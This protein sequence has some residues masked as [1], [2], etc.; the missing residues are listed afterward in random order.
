MESFFSHYQSAFLSVCAI[1][2]RLPG[3]TKI[4]AITPTP[5]ATKAAQ[6]MA[7]YP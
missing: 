3:F 6:N 1:V 4:M 7:A 5:A 2:M